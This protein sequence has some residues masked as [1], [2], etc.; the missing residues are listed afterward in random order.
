MTLAQSDSINLVQKTLGRCPDHLVAILKRFGAVLPRF[1]YGLRIDL[2]QRQNHLG[3][4]WEV[5]ERRSRMVGRIWLGEIHTTPPTPELAGA[6]M[7]KNLYR[8]IRA[9]PVQIVGGHT[10]NP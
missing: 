2:V 8:C 4:V 7:Q 10:N 3:D 1:G 6:P 5:M 9:L